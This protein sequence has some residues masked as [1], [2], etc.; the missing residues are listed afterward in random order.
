MLG[1]FPGRSGLLLR[2]DQTSLLGFDLAQEEDNSDRNTET[3]QD[4]GKGAECPAE[5]DLIIKQLRNLRTGKSRGDCRRAVQSDDSHTIPQGS[6]I[7]ENDSND[8]DESKM[9]N[10]ENRLRGSVRLN[11]L[12]RCLHDHTDGDEED[13]AGESFRT[14]A[15]IDNL[16]DRELGDTAENRG[17]NAGRRKQAM[18]TERGGH[19]RRQVALNR[20]Q[21]AVGEGNEVQT[22]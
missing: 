21:E 16:G 8:V 17:D 22:V 5:V 3:D 18:L 4:D 2:R 12:A 19:V 9:A 1:R 14:A 15:N 20:L 10:P 7:G 11:V 13:H 6:H